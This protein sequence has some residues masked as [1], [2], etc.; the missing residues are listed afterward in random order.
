[1]HLSPRSHVSID[2]DTIDLHQMPRDETAFCDW[3]ADASAG[4]AIP[5]YR[6]HLGFDR[7]APKSPLA[8]DHRRRLDRLADRVL[9]AARSGFVHLVQRR[10]GR[11]DW[12]YIAVRARHL[13]PAALPTAL[14]IPPRPPIAANDAVA[15][16][17]ITLVAA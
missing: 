6:G 13:A 9:T 16:A 14:S 11:N 3:L 12:I 4:A 1:M 5:Y 8:Q 17:P 7:A 10:A 15:F 2:A